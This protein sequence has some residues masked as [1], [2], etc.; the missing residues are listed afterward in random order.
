[1]E[2]KRGLRAYIPSASTAFGFVDQHTE[3]VALCFM[4]AHTKEHALFANY[5]FMVIL[6]VLFRVI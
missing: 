2:E 1:M 4:T 3:D 6:A 5:K